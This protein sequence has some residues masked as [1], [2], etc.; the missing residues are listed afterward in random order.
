MGFDNQYLL[1]SENVYDKIIVLEQRAIKHKSF[2][3]PEGIWQNLIDGWL[4]F[5]DFLGQGVNKS[6]NAF[7]H[8]K[9]GG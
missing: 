2:Q 6:S 4:P 8:V 1:F 9:V 5:I 3:L 7:R